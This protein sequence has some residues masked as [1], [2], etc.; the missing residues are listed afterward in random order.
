M[1]HHEFQFFRRRPGAGDSESSAAP[2]FINGAPAASEGLIL[3]PSLAASEGFMSTPSSAA[4]EDL[5]SAGTDDLASAV[6]CAMIASLGFFR[7]SPS[8]SGAEAGVNT[9]TDSIT[10]SSKLAIL[11]LFEVIAAIFDTFG[12]S[13]SCNELKAFSCFAAIFD[14]GYSVDSILASA[15]A[16]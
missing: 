11:L 5:A 16:E 13:V 6:V 3:V 1:S 4:S 7:A 15:G 14:F 10:A 12:S 8:A 9:F 2:S